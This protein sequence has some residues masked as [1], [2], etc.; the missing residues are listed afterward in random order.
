MAALLRLLHS[1]PFLLVLMSD[2]FGWAR[3][4]QKFF[5]T[6]ETIAS[7]T[8]LMTC[9]AERLRMFIDEGQHRKA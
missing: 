7:Q 6:D 4:R 3:I 1:L 5:R 8:S 9:E 2:S